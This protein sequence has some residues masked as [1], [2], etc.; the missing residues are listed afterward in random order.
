MLRAYIN[1]N[2]CLEINHELQS[3]Y[4]APSHS[5]DSNLAFSLPN[6]RRSAAKEEIAKAIWEAHE[7]Y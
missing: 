2:E 1:P 6:E 5:G 3:S 4:L 7:S